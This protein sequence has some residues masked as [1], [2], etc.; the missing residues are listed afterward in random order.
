MSERRKDHSAY[1]ARFGFTCMLCYEPGNENHHIDPLSKGG[2]DDEENLILLCLPCH[3]LHG[4]HSDFEET[5]FYL[6]FKKHYFEARYLAEGKFWLKP[7]EKP[8]EARSSQGLT[9][10]LPEEE[11]PAEGPRIACTRLNRRHY[12]LSELRSTHRKTQKRSEILLP[13]VSLPLSRKGQDEGIQRRFSPPDGQIQPSR[14]GGAI[15]GKETNRV[16]HGI[17]PCGCGRQVI[18]KPTKKYATRLCRF[19][20]RNA[21][22]KEAYKLMLQIE[23]MSQG[24]KVIPPEGP[25]RDRFIEI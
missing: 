16:N 8:V 22:K 21:R 11:R 10:L 23:E 5:E 7:D 18:G 15:S 1:K 3:D 2:K 19:K 17:C 4:I 24:L 12:G 13:K 14:T 9:A 20:P 25:E 6:A